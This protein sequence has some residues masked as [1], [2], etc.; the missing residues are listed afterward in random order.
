MVMPPFIA[1]ELLEQ[2]DLPT[3]N[4]RLASLVHSTI[5]P[6]L[7]EIHT[8]PQS[9]GP[10]RAQRPSAADIEKLAHLVLDPNIQLSSDFIGKL[11]QEGHSIEDLFVTLLEPAARCLGTMWDNDECSFVDVTYGV[12][13]LQQLLSVGSHSH[14]VPEFS[15]KR[16]VCMVTLL[17]EKHSLGV[18][19]VETFLQAGGW[20]VTSLHRTSAEQIAAIVGSEWF[21][22]A[23]LTIG[24]TGQIPQLTSTIR[25]IRSHSCNPAIG[26]MVGGPPFPGHGEIVAE[27][28]ADATAI[29]APAAVLVA[30]RL[31]DVGAARNWQAEATTTSRPMQ[32]A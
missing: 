4:E 5:V 31:F 25:A 24:S 15:R 20:A 1:P 12:A 22:V 29:N 28:G 13:R 32:L 10:A 2:V 7:I 11:E 8:R 9:G 16:S 23:G 3:M 26:I 30:Q 17:D 18:T 19:M 27:V 21:A 14:A 6:R